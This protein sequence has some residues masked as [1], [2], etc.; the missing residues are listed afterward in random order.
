MSGELN[1]TG[2][3]PVF[4][5]GAPNAGTSPDDGS[6]EV[7]TTCLTITRIFPKGCKRGMNR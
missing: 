2:A 6:P 1:L 3:Q 7:K 5:R 4:E